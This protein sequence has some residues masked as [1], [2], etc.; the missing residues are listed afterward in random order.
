MCADEGIEISC[1]ATSCSFAD[2]DKAAVQVES[3]RAFIELAALVGARRLR[4]FGGAI[5]EGCERTRSFDSVVSSLRAL[6]PTARASGVD[7]CVETHDSWCDAREVKRVMEAVADERIRV[8]WDIMHPVLT[9][10]QSMAEAFGLLSPWISHV[11][12]HD[13]TRDDGT[14]RFLPI[15]TGK[16]D[17]LSAVRLLKKTNYAGYLSGE[18][19]GW[20]APELHLGRELGTMKKYEEE[21]GK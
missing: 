5:P 19:I 18:W 2:P 20:E 6:A 12:I 16:V 1:V 10:G 11:H 9:A 15:G 14:L 3:A 4:V 21:A 8:N 13:G 7:V 17:H